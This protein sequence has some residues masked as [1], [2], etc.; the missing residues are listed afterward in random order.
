MTKYKIF[1]ID[2]NKQGYEF[3]DADEYTTFDGLLEINRGGKIT[4]FPLT[5]VLCFEAEEYEEVEKQPDLEIQ[6]AEAN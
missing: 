6:P 1:V 4:F 2:A 5:N 3:N